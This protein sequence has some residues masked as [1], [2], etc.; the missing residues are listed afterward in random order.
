MA[1]YKVYAVR[2]GRHPG[3]YYSWEECKA[4]IIG[5][6]NAE[7][8]SFENIEDAQAYLDADGLDTETTEEDVKTYAFVDGSFNPSTNVYGYGGF[9]VNNGETFL[10][11]GSGNDPDMASMRNISGEI[12]G[13]KAA[14]EEAINQ[15]IEEITIF[16]DY[17]GIEKWAIGEWKRN[18]DGTKDYYDYVQSIKDNLKI[19]F[20]KVAGHTGIEGNEEADR[21]AKEAVGIITSDV[22]DPELLPEEQ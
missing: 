13:A 8:K 14:M 2:S 11:Q 1:S 12:L 18:K 4:E 6:S 15:G 3:L 16:Y 17:I 21:L 7:Y 20:V 19:H 10:L 5:F 9:L 22:F